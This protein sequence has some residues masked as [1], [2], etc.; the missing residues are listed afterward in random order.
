MIGRISSWDVRGEDF[1]PSEQLIDAILAEAWDKVG[2][3]GK[4]R[5]ILL[6]L[7]TK[8]LSMRAPKDAAS[9]LGGVVLEQWVCCGG[10][11]KLG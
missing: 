4:G 8:T 6:F 5:L 11:T 2:D 9:T 1:V 3:G 7:A 10:A